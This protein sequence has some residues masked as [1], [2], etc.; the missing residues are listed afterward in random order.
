MSD[1][2]EFWKMVW[3]MKAITISELRRAVKTEQ[4]P[5]GEISPE[6][7]KQ[8]SGEDFIKVEEPQTLPASDTPVETETKPVET[9]NTTETV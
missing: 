8:I 3:N 1:N 5:F 4:N 6:E 9:E 2:Y 7:F